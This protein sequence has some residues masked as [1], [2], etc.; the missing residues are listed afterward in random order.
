MSTEFIPKDFTPQEKIKRKGFI[1][2][3]L[4]PQHLDLD[5]VAVM[6]SIDLIKQIRGGDWPSED[7]TKE[8]DLADL[9]WHEDEFNKRASFAYTVLNQAKTECLG[10][11][12]LYPADKPWVST[13]E[14][15]DV[16]ISMWVTQE[17]YDKGLYP[18]L[19]K[20]VKQWIQ[21]DWPFKNPYY[22]NKEIPE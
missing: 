19:F 4:G 9:E 7:L 15:S 17:A 21:K 5:Y 22:S 11:V 10:C 13:P 18:K 3:K 1:L 12:Y 16:D 6:S 8:K 2:E 20:S 14:G